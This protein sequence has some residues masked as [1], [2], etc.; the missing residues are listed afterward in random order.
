VHVAL[1]TVSIDPNQQDAARANLESQVVPMVRQNPG[2]KWGVWL[3]PKEGMGMSMVGFDTKENAEAA[4]AQVPAEP[5]PGVKVL[6]KEV[7]EV[8]AGF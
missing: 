8:V 5:G 1:V 3:D 2:V 7:R 6:T 4:L